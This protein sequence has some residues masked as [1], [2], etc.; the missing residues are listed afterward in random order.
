MTIREILRSAI[1]ESTTWSQNRLAV[2]IGLSGPAMSNRLK[3]DGRDVKVGFVV[4]VLDRLGYDLV[5]VRKGSRLPNG[6]VVVTAEE[7]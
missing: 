4:A 6:S 3:A 1:D 5:V 2:D 7:E